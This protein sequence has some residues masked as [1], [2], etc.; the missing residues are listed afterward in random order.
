M[1]KKYFFDLDGTLYQFSNSERTFAGSLLESS[2]R[3]NIIKYMVEVFWFSI[4]HASEKYI[5]CQEKYWE[6]FSIAFEREF[7]IDKQDFFEY[8]WDID[9]KECID[10][11]YDICELFSIF[12]SQAEIYIVSDAPKIWIHRVIEFLDI[13]KYIHTIYS[14]EWD[15]RKTNGKLYDKINDEVWWKKIMMWDQE[16]SDIIYA[17]KKW[18]ITVYVNEN[19]NKSKYADYNVKHIKD[20]WKRIIL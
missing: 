18:F 13:W 12:S 4:T 20:I 1:N 17:N 8:I 2:I 6:D 9:P 15:Y 7:N 10:L 11:D 3:K 14:W 5:Y 16:E 19:W